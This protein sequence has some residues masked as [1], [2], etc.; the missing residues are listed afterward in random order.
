MVN[1][2]AQKEKPAEE[3]KEPAE[4]KK[5]DKEEEKGKEEKKEDKKEKRD[6][7]TKIAVIVMIVLIASVLLAH[8]IVQES[9]TFEYEGIKFYKYKEDST[10][11]YKSEIMNYQS[12]TGLFTGTKSIPFA[13]RLRNDPRELR[14][15][16]VEGTILLNQQKDIILSVSPE[17]V[18]CNSTHRT[19]MDYAWTL[20]SFGFNVSLATPDKEYAKENNMTFVTCSNNSKGRNLILMWEGNETKITQKGNCCFMEINN[21]EAQES[22]GRFILGFIVNS[23][24]RTQEESA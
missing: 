3:K 17:L 16:P 7:Q 9:K 20:S 13:I 22:F 2:K 23:V 5:E 1:K 19:L 10:V 8:W 11:F 24:K 21:C 14:K 12:Y 6:K 18:K 4:K 15:I